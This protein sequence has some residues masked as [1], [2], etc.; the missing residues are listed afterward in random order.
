MASLANPT[1]SSRTSPA[2]EGCDRCSCMADEWLGP[3]RA[4][5]L[6]PRAAGCRAVQPATSAHDRI[7]V[8]K[9]I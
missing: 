1:S 5:W 9:L 3:K 4:Y 6:A 8:A 7:K 2:L